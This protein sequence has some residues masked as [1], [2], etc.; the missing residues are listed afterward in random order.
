MGTRRHKRAGIAIW[1]VVAAVFGVLLV[2]QPALSDGLKQTEAGSRPQATEGSQPEAT[3]PPTPPAVVTP[4][5]AKQKE[6]LQETAELV[7]L[8]TDLKTEVDR[9]NQGVLSVKVVEKAD[10]ISQLARTLRQKL[11]KN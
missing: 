6:L 2:W 8:A 5:D 3:K 7:R 10:E 9:T 11:K 4:R 1:I